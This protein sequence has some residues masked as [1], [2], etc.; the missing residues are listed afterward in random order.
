MYDSHSLFGYSTVAAVSSQTADTVVLTVQ[1]GN[2]SLFTT[3]QQVTIWPANAQPLLPNAMVGRIT[4]ISGDQLT[5]S[6]TSLVREGSNTRTVAVN[7][8]I[9]N[10]VTPKVLTDIESAVST[11][12]HDTRYYTESEVDTLIAA[13]PDVVMNE[14]PG[15]TLD[16]SN[17]VFTT[18]YAYIANST[19]LFLNGQRM[20]LLGDYIE[21]AVQQITFVEAPHTGDILTIDY[22]KT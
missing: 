21:S 3:N 7:D 10:T 18:A 9:A 22:L 2:G 1:T 16:G 12:T 5:I 6:I 4:G 14:T 20:Q 11:H 17:A 8:Q 15:G 13:I 19:R